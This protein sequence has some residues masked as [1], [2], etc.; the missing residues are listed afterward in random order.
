MNRL[1]LSFA[2]VGALTCLTLTPVTAAAASAFVERAKNECVV[3]EQADGYLGFV[4]GA[5][6]SAALRREVRDINQRRKAI[7]AD[8]AHKNGVSI[9]VTAALTAEKLIRRAT[10]GQ[11][12]RDQNGNWV[13]I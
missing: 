13:E 9:N 7:Y 3:G 10:S 11:C 6:V 12:V 5:T 8:L 2:A 1:L 4:P